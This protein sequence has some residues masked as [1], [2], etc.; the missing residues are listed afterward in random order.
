MMEGFGLHSS[1]KNYASS[2]PEIV[3]NDQQIVDAAFNYFR[4]RGFPYRK[5][6][7]HVM[8]Q[9]VNRLARSENKALFRSTVGYWVADT[10]HPHRFHGRHHA[11][12]QS[13]VEVFQSDKWL[14]QALEKELKLSGQIRTALAGVSFVGISRALFNFRP[15]FALL[16]Y[17]KFC[18]PGATVLDTSTGYGGRL[19]GF[20]ASKC[21]R[22]IGI[23]PNVPTYEGN[24]KMASD[25]G[26]SADVELYNL[27]AEDVDPDILRERCDFAFTSPPYFRTEIYSDAPT[28]SC[29]RYTEQDEWKMGFM[30]PLMKLQ[31]AALKPGCYSCMNVADTTY[32]GNKKDEHIPLVAWT[33][34]AALAAGFIHESTKSYSIGRHLGRQG[35]NR[36]R[37]EGPTHKQR[38]VVLVLKKPE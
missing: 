24:L 12:A 9:E 33:T 35:V 32:R 21:G 5:L 22:Y 10:Y 29:N 30:Y 8:L 37:G 14:R 4:E 38:E 18:K 11:K 20:F 3:F 6:P 23:D 36:E 26:R 28:Q 31:Y 7:L 19:V 1:A 16:M 17:R 15:G 25:F 27:P 34:E 2:S 13:P